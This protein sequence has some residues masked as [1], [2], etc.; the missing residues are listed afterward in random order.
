MKNKIL[1]VEDEPIIADE[2]EALLSDL[3]YEI[4][5]I[6]LDAEE[7]IEFIKKESPELILLD[8]SLDGDID[9]VMLAEIINEK[10]QIPFV[11]LTSHADKLTV[12]RVKR[13][14]PSGF[15]LKPYNEKEL[16]SNIEIAL[17]KSAP[18]KSISDDFFIKDG[19]SWVKINHSDILYA[20]AD[21][22][23]TLIFT[24]DKKYI[25]SSTLKKLETGLPKDK[26]MRIHRSYIVNLKKIDKISDGFV[27]FNKKNI[28]IGRNYQADFFNTIQK[29]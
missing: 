15:I 1:I 20:Q 26:F 2:L 22:N 28:P 13:T 11:F 14:K 23:Y 8:I 4:V 24:Q 27:I 6:A 5:G 16:A 3:G 7:A 25:L 18:I 29:L 21:D 10:F 9:G 19:S 12:N 17:Y